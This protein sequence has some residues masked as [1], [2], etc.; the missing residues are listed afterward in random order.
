MDGIRDYHTS[1]VSQTG[2]DKY[3]MISYVWNQKL[4]Q[5]NLF[6]E[7]ETDSQDSTILT[8]FYILY[9]TKYNI[10][11]DIVHFLIG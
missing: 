10:V 4:I 8:S 5:M 11:Q 9:R 1:E 2:K 6:K 7:A 3:H